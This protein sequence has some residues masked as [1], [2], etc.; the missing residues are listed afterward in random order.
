MGGFYSSFSFGLDCAPRCTYL[1]EGGPDSLARI[2]PHRSLIPPALVSME[3][4]IDSDM[5]QHG[6]QIGTRRAGKDHTD[7]RVSSSCL[8]VWLDRGL[9]TARTLDRLPGSDIH[10]MDD[11]HPFVRFPVLLALIF[12]G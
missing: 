10:A 2:H 5:W 11:R 4:Q 9:P 8:G 3:E 6:S 1:S 12:G 7:R